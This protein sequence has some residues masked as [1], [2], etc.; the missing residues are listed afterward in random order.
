MCKFECH[1]F[2]IKFSKELSKSKGL[3]YDSL[4][5]EINHITCITSPTDAEKEHLYLY[6]LR[7]QLNTFYVEKAKG[8][9]VLSRASG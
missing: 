8:A 3:Q 7:E 9:F 2:S 5:K 4:L 6:L 1:N